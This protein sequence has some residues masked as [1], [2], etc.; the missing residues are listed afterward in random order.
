MNPTVFS[1]VRT[2][3]GENP[4]CVFINLG[5]RTVLSVNSILRI[6]EFPPNARGRIL[7]AT[8]TSNYN[9]DDIV[10]VDQFELREYDAIAFVVEEGPAVVTTTTTEATTPDSASTV[11]ATFMIMIMSVLVILL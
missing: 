7:A 2:L 6:D 3:D 4:V 1:Y 5:G 11:V 10:D 8:S 9:I